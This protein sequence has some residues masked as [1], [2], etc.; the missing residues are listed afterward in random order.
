MHT[1]YF[2]PNFL[3]SLEFIIILEIFCLISHVTITD[4]TPNL[5]PHFAIIHLAY[6]KILDIIIIHSLEVSLK[7]SGLLQAGLVAL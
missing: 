2:M 5:H 7:A 1:F 3:F 6:S 4:S